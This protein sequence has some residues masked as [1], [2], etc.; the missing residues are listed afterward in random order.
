MHPAGGGVHN[1][2]SMYCAV[3]NVTAYTLYATLQRLQS[4]GD[5][6][7]LAVPAWGPPVA[8]E[9]GEG[10]RHEGADCSH[11]GGH[12]HG[13][14][15]EGGALPALLVGHRHGHPDAVEDGGL[16]TIVQLQ[17]VLS[18]VQSTTDLAVGSLAHDTVPHLLVGGQVLGQQLQVVQHRP[19]EFQGALRYLGLEGVVGDAVHD[20]HHGQ[21]VQGALRGVP[22]QSTESPQLLYTSE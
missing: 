3:F 9:V 17:R 21:G 10:G 18:I 14:L 15:E 12:V 5:G 2:A 4:G 16:D 7:V 22:P 11:G 6:L 8:G 13:A 19:K 20:G 1:K